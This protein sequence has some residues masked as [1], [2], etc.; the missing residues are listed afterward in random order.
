MI[1]CWCKSEL[2]SFLR[3]DYGECKNCG[4]LV[5]LCQP[6]DL[7]LKQ[8]YKF[9][10]Y[11]HQ[12]MQKVAQPTIETRAVADFNDRIPYWYKLIK[13]HYPKAK[14][15]F[16]IGCAHGGFLHYCL[17]NGLEHAH[18]CEV[19]EDT[20]DFAREHFGLPVVV[21]GLFPNIDTKCL[22]KGY[23]VVCGFDVIEHFADPVGALRVVKSVMN[24]NARCFFQS[25]HYR[26]EGPSFPEFKPKEHLYVFREN[27]V[28]RLMAI[29]GMDV[30]WFGRSIF[31]ND[32][33]VVTKCV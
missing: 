19:D 5:S 21:S 15:V 22:L 33:M 27:S 16:E 20:C 28:R 7:E 18:G 31:P 26:E 9:G 14:S 1:H 29:A 24:T 10:E 32:W 3:P 30:L 8:Q 11:W 17:Q 6:N 13:S 25:P 12:Q 4:T 2:S 23:D